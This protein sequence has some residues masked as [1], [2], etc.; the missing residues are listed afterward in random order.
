GARGAVVHL[1]GLAESR[2]APER[3]LKR[4]AARC[5]SLGR[6]LAACS[7]AE[8]KLECWAVTARAASALLP[9]AVR[10]AL[11]LETSAADA[12]YWGFAR[13]AINEHPEVALRLAD[14]AM[15]DPAQCVTVLVESMLQADAEDE[16]VLTQA[17]RY[18]VRMDS[19]PFM[20][21]AAR[22]WDGASLLRLEAAVPGQLKNLRWTRHPLR[23]PGEGEVAIEVRAA[24]LNFRDVMYAM[25]QLSDE[26]LESG[27][28]GPTLGMEVAG[29]VS[30]LG[31]GVR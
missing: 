8:G 23:S 27:F 21:R 22:E 5:D 18:V 19:A 14:L 20:Q 16:L 31:R 2:L 4:Q 10:A 17:G 28:A 29:V 11:R 25:G 24:G 30:E 13:S 12:A 7:A 6:M 15:P 26:A 9:E 1:C 3:V